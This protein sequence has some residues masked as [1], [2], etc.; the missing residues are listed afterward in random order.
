MGLSCII[1]CNT[2]KNMESK[3]LA[4][5]KNLL[6]KYLE[7]KCTD[8][9][10]LRMYNLLIMPE[11]ELSVKEILL[12]HL[13]EFDETGIESNVDFDHIYQRIINEI[14]DCEKLEGEKLKIER[15]AGIIR[16]IKISVRVA[17]IFIPAFVFGVIYMYLT[18][19]GAILN[20]SPLNFCEIKAPLGAK[21]DII[22]PDGSHV[23]LNAGSTIKYYSDFNIKNRNLLLEGEAYFKVTKNKRIPLI[24]RASNINIRAVGTEFNVKAY[25][26]ERLVE[27][28]L[29]EGVVEISKGGDKVD[30]GDKISLTP[31]QKAVDRKS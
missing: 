2:L 25:K 21:A 31:N 3:P 15:K 8:E 18:S 23:L 26:N 30:K 20:T 27:T 29:V 6:I 19:G 9:E 1:H 12:Q 22:L 24:V 28:T 7:Q 16:L 17:A 4:D 5:L 13:H 10:K 11:N 14:E